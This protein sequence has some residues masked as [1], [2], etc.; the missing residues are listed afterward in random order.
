MASFKEDEETVIFV[1]EHESV[2]DE[3][4]MSIFEYLNLKYAGIIKLNEEVHRMVKTLYD[5][6]VEKRGI[7]KGELQA[8]REIVKSQLTKKLG[9]IPG[10]ISKQIEKADC[11]TLTKILDDI[12]DIISFSDLESYFSPGN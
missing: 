8:K 1:E 11:Q 6:E 5:P 4:K 9:S 12:F 10:H 2:Q 7:E 3:L